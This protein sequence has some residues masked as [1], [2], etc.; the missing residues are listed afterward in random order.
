MGVS[1]PIVAQ[2]LSALTG[3]APTFGMRAGIL[4]V[5]T[6]I[7]TTSVTLG[8]KRG[9]KMLSWINVII[10]LSMITFAFLVGPTTQIVNSFTNAV[11]KMT[12]NFFDMLFWTAPWQADSFPQDWTIFYALWMASY[13]PF[14]GLFIARISRGR[15]VR[16]VLL[17]S[18]FGGMSGAF[19]IH[20][21]FGS[22][23]L[24]AQMTGLVDAVAILKEHGGPAALIAVLQT[25]PGSSF[26]L[27]GY[28]CFSTIFL[29]TSVD[30]S[31]Y[32]MASASTR[33]LV[34]GEDPSLQSRFFWAVIQG[35][36][37]LAIISMEDG[38]GPVKIFANFAGALM[39]L[40]IA[41]A[42]IAWFKFIRSHN[43][44]KE[45]EENALAEAARF[46]AIK[47]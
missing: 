14:M 3:L 22:Y 17:M 45:L 18:I 34:P 21:V 38:L 24:N 10:A 8:L 26:I 4:L 25:L 28:C 9:I 42:V 37:A 2:A 36:L 12:G 16:Q 11:G 7:F 43:M 20:G 6:A 39:L 32:I 40:P 19:L 1:L 44:Q 35:G 30:S 31:A 13:G 41:F 5:S 23:T 29:A 33:R 27:V 15:N 46:A 47:G